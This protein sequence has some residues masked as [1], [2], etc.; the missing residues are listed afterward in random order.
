LSLLERE[1]I[2]DVTFLAPAN[3]YAGVGVTDARSRS[4]WFRLSLLAWVKMTIR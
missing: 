3:D 2:G 4:N 1:S